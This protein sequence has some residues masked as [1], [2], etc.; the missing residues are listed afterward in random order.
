MN[1]GQFRRNIFLED[2]GRERLG[3]G[4]SDVDID[5]SLAVF[6]EVYLGVGELDLVGGAYAGERRTVDGGRKKLRGG[7]AR[8]EDPVLDGYPDLPAQALLGADRYVGIAFS[9]YRFVNPVAIGIYLIFHP[10]NPLQRSP[11]RAQI[12][13]PSW[14]T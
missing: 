13:G 12:Y 8:E 9:C 14:L 10:L 2:K 7:F 1:R 11:C 3:R 5:F 6:H 4:H